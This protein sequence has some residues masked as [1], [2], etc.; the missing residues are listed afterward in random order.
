MKDKKSRQLGVGSL[1][2]TVNLELYTVI[3]KLITEN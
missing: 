1:L 2:P 3:C